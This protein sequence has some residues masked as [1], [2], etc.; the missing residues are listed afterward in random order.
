MR[1]RR[2]RRWAPNERVAGCVLQSKVV[3]LF[4]GVACWRAND[5]ASGDPVTVVTCDHLRGGVRARDFRR[6][7]EIRQRLDGRA[8]KPL[9]WRKMLRAD[10]RAGAYVLE[11]LEAC[12][13]EEFLDRDPTP[14]LR[15][16]LALRLLKLGAF[17]GDG[18]VVLAA[19]HPRLL[20]VDRDNNLVLLDLSLA[21]LLPVKESAPVPRECNRYTAPEIVLDHEQ[22]SLRSDVFTFGNL[23]LAVFNARRPRS[24]QNGDFLLPGCSKPRSS[25][26]VEKACFDEAAARYASVRDALA[27]VR[28]LFAEPPPKHE[29]EPTKVGETAPSSTGEIQQATE[30]RAPVPWTKIVTVALTVLGWFGKIFK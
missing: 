12:T 10:K 5:V 25:T 19:A 11:Q 7:I 3:E 4:G 16:L 20:G 29:Q 28:L 17:L 8:P 15:T 6:G 14:K 18:E 2:R 1:A 27:D 13:L 23:V 24:R 21:Q 9:G 30:R 22:P 26:I